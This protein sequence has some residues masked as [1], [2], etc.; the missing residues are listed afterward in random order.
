[1]P[2]GDL[3]PASLGDPI[4]EVTLQVR[5][6]HRCCQHIADLLVFM[7]VSANGA[8]WLAQLWQRSACVAVEPLQRREV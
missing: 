6:Y 4:T 3:D 2:S 7:S 8:A 5:R 1:M